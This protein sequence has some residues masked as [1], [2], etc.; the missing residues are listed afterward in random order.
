MK[1]PVCGKEMQKGS[2]GNYRSENCY[3][4]P[5]GYFNSHWM[6][7]A[8]TSKNTI[9]RDGGIIVKVHNRVLSKPTVAY[10]C[11]E[12]KMVLVDCND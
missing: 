8:A 7:P 12:C 10:A 6:N 5:D 9:E 1:C 4:V 2:F 3:W 11:P